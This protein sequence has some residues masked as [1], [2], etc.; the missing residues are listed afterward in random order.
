MNT[1]L[2]IASRYDG[3]PL[4]PLEL[5]CKD[6]FTH[7]TPEKLCRKISD[8][9]IALPIVKL[10]ASQKSARAVHVQDLANYIDNQRQIALSEHRKFHA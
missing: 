8:G 9:S 7:L 3:M 5:V 2:L 4:L 10:E 1:A 6:F